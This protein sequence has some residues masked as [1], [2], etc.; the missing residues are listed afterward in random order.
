[1]TKKTNFAGCY[2]LKLY[3]NGEPQVVVVDDYFPFDDRPEKDSWAF[4]SVSGEWAIYAN[5]IE[6]AIAKAIGSYE[7]IEN[8]KAY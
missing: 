5:L 4:G 1:M 7:A 2:A 8:G 3:I 6:K